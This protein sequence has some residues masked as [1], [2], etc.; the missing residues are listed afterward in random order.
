MGLD[1]EKER[2]TCMYSDVKSTEPFVIPSISINILLYYIVYSFALFFPTSFLMFS[3]S[4]QSKSPLHFDTVYYLNGP[5]PLSSLLP[6]TTGLA[7]CSEVGLYGI[8][9]QFLISYLAFI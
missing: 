4:I 6:L 9:I 8:D 3:L 7:L 2:V 1:C 5:F